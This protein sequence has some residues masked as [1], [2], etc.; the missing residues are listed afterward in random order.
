MRIF[1]KIFI[2]IV[3]MTIA[4]SA[5]AQDLLRASVPEGIAEQFQLA[6]L[7]VKIGQ[8]DFGDPMIS[9]SASGANF[10]LYF[11]NCQDG[12]DCLSVQFSACF[13]LIEGEKMTVINSWNS[14][15][16]YG[17]AHLDEEFDPCL[18]MDVDMAG[19]TP[20]A[21]FQSALD[22]WTKILGRFVGKIDY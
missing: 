19:G 12:K 21:T 3:C 8:D 2:T 22:T 15:M 4:T 10:D 13:D 5:L 9:S 17:K 14:D 20:V 7:Q 18:K 16:R 1:S 6:G 11:Y